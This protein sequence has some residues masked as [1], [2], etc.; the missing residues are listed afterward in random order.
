[1]NRLSIY[2]KTMKMNKEFSETLST[3]PESSS[4]DDDESF[5]SDE[6]YEEEEINTIQPQSTSPLTSACQQMLAKT[7]SIPVGP[8][9]NVDK[10]TAS[11]PFKITLRKMERFTN[12]MTLGLFDE[13]NLRLVKESSSQ[14]TFIHPDE[15]SRAVFYDPTHIN[16]NTDEFDKLLGLKQ[17]SEKGKEH[18]PMQRIMTKLKSE[19]QGPVMR[20]INT[21]LVMTRI[22][23]N[24]FIW[25]D[26]MLTFWFLLFLML[27]MFILAV[28][29]WRGFILLVGFLAFGPQVSLICTPASIFLVHTFL[30]LHQCRICFSKR[31]Y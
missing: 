3:N 23:V 14:N 11:V 1:M 27:M 2:H 13:V 25:K 19:Y 7:S 24:L 28:F 4:D 12:K 9:Q 21:G 8:E 26:P 31:K 6:E 17:V 15:N 18:R 5:S 30:S 20:M 29:P 16:H 10:K 22:L